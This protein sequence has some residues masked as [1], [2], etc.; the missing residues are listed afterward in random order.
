VFAADSVRFT[1]QREWQSPT[2]GAR[3]P[4]H[5]QI[6]TPAGHFEVRALLDAQELDS[7]ASTGTVYWEGLSE[8]RDAQ[9]RIVGHGYLEMTGYAAPLRL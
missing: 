5:W 7:R 3:Y 8:L 2:S 6:D 1:P 4:L 9:D